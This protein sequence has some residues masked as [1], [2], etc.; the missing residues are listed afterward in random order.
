MLQACE[1]L[2]DPVQGLPSL[3]GG[4]FVQVRVR[5]LTPDP[6]LLLQEFHELQLD[7]PPLTIQEEIKKEIEIIKIS[8]TWKFFYFLF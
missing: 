4:G 8:N 5:T 1:S 7:H 3:L 2:E 6:H